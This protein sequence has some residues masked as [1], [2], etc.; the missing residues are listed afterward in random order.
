MFLAPSIRS[1][2]QR[3]FKTNY[4]FAFASLQ[5][6]Y[7][8]FF[9]S[10]SRDQTRSRPTQPSL[11]E[12]GQPASQQLLP[13]LPSI[14]VGNII[15][16]RPPIRRSVLK[17]KTDRRRKRN[18]RLLTQA[19]SLFS[20]ELAYKSASALPFSSQDPAFQTSTFFIIYSLDISLI[21][22]A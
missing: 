19:N 20:H 14:R 13:S 21:A 3:F 22:L 2:Q 12:T 8:R 7:D 11:L 6:F 18:H 5:S 17:R 1:H 4:H 16:E 10:L 15:S 9:C